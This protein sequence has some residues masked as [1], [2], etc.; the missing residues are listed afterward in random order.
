MQCIEM[1]DDQL[2]RDRINNGT[3]LDVTLGVETV[4]LVQQ[5]QHGS[6]DLSFTS[7]VWLISTREKPNKL[8]FINVST[9]ATVS[10]RRIIYENI[11]ELQTEYLIKL[12]FKLC[13]IYI[14]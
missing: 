12:I 9:V 14:V 6:L 2:S 13:T 10:R 7:G 11:A 5:L 4:E 8:V 3:Y 1:K